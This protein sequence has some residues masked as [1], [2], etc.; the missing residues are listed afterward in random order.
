MYARG[1]TVREIQGVLRE[2]YGTEVSP[3][4]ISSV[5]DEVLE[6]VAAWQSPPL[7]TM[8]PVVFFDALRVKI[9]EEAVVLNKAVYLAPASPLRAHSE[10]EQLSISGR[11]Q[12]I[13][14][15]D[16]ATKSWLTSAMCCVRARWPESIF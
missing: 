15:D 13:R 2:Q 1:M 16:T 12:A 3:E 10:L 6:E 14:S 8:Y 11:G 4:F 9:R 5:T 7:E